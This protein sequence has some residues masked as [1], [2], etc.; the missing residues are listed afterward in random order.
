MEKLYYLLILSIVLPWGVFML[1]YQ[2]GVELLKKA[3][4]TRKNYQGQRIPTAGGLLLFLSLMI[5][6]VIVTIFMVYFELFVGSL[7]LMMMFLAGSIAIVCLGWQDDGAYD[8]TSKGFQGHL[9]ILIREKRMTS[10]M[11]KAFGGLGT[12]VIVCIPISYSVVEGIINILLLGLCTNLIN[13]FDLRPARA[14]KV[15]WLIA[16][17]IFFFSPFGD[18]YVAWIWF[19]PLLSATLWFFF[20][21]ARGEIMLG[22]TGSNFLGYMIGFEMIL[23][24][25]LPA[26][27]T[28]LFLL[29][30]LHL[31]AERIS[32]SQVIQSKSWLRWVD[33]F[34]RNV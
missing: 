6:W 32:L 11:L 5:T 10:G 12:A 27:I 24:L 22:D 16:M 25:S 7:R 29:I 3:G 34:G 18:W 26:K 20:R 33:Q 21:D 28:V 23:T 19:L 8:T 2:P 31:L 14:I 30:I 13:L 9:R 15:F 1:I 17:P 4:M